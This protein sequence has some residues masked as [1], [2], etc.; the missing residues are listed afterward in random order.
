MLLVGFFLIC[1]L[2]KLLLVLCLML[3]FHRVALIYFGVTVLQEK[4]ENLDELLVLY[5]LPFD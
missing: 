5:S 2:A 1:D 3:K 4:L